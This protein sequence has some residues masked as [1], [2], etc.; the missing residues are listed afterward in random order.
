MLTTTPRGQIVNV[1]W[2]I[3][4]KYESAKIGVCSIIDFSNIYVYI[5]TTNTES[6]NSLSIINV[7]KSLKADELPDLG[8]TPEKLHWSTAKLLFPDGQ[9]NN[10]RGNGETG[11]LDLSALSVQDLLENG[12]D[13]RKLVSR[14]AR[15]LFPKGSQKHE[16]Q[17]ILDNKLLGL[18]YSVSKNL[19][20]TPAD[21][22]LQPN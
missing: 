6:G 20:L 22:S 2:I 19:V 17:Q 8:I 14:I 5:M 3:R 4:A 13:V 1:E 11:E 18:E 15:L 21:N 7:L 12:V 10:M 9:N 16:V